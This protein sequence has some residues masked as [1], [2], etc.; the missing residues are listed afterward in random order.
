ML[1]IVAPQLSSGHNRLVMTQW[2]KTRDVRF[3]SVIILLVEDSELESR[4]ICCHDGKRAALAA[5]RTTRL[6][7]IVTERNINTGVA[8]LVMQIF[9]PTRSLLREKIELLIEAV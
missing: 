3:D 1:T 7:S 9:P 6:R 8:G 4:G 2:S 5:T